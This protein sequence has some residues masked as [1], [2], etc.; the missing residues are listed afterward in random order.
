VP[1]PDGPVTVG[2]R[3]EHLELR[4]AADDGAV[5]ARVDFVEPL[6]SHVLVNALVGETKVIVQAPAGVELASGTQIG[7]AL[8]PGRT[9][10][11]DTASGEAR[12]SRQRIAL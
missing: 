12:R 4:G 11:F 10:F 8:P 9:Y 2:A 5:P 3:P 1:E 6:G 7:L